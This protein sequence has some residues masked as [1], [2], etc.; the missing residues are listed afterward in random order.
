MANIIDYIQWRGDLSLKESGFNEIDSLILNRFSYLP[1]DEI[2]KENEIVTIKELSERFT[3][4]DINQMQI[5]WDDDVNLFPEMGKLT[6][7]GE[8]KAT[9]YV[10]KISVE[11]EKQFSAI[12]I[13]IP[14]D[15]IYIYHIEEQTTQ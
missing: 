11:Q 12:T 5:L 1:F 9:K 7:F 13:I 15:T 4:K 10:N 2:I 3:S 8:M 14:D 6:R